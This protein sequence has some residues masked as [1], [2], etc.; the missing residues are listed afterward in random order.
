MASP[1]EK[2]AESLQILHGLQNAN[3]AAAIRAKDMTRTH[4]ERLLANG[5]F[6]GGDKGMVHPEPS[7]RSKR[8]EHGLVRVILALRSSVSRNPLRPEL[9]PVS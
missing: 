6:S 9:V 7:G 3:G 8:R 2:L 5:F 4:R 1:S